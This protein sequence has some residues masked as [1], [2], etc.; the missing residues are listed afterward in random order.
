DFE[1]AC[2][3]PDGTAASNDDC[4]DADPEVGPPSLWYADDDGDGFGAGEPID[5]DPSCDSPAPG[6]RPEWVGLDCGEGDPTIYPG[7]EEV[8]E[9]GID[10]DCD[11]LDKSCRPECRAPSVLTA[12]SPGG[13]MALCDDPAD[14]TCEQD[15]GDLCPVSWHLCSPEQY[16]ARNAGWAEPLPPNKALGTIYCRAGDSGAGHYSL[17][18]AGIGSLGEDEALNCGYG[19]SR[20]TCESGYGCN[21]QT[22]VALCCA[23]IP[24]CGNGRVDHAEELCDD[25]N[26]D[27]TDDCLNNCSWRNPVAHGLFGIG[28]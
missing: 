21:E 12:V 15:F 7:A 10:Q 27:E 5:P 23:P 20:A 8:C 28:C 17:S 6:A 22:S 1:Y 16:N 18:Y 11:G 26:F 9:D 25:G 4:D 24:T 14:I 13:D 2:S 19:S 3:R